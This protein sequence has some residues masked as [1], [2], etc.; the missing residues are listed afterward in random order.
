MILTQY[1]NSVR[2]RWYHTESW[3]IFTIVLFYFVL[4]DQRACQHPGDAT[5]LSRCAYKFLQFGNFCGENQQFPDDHGYLTNPESCGPPRWLLQAEKQQ[6]LNG[7]TTQEVKVGRQNGWSLRVGEVYYVINKDCDRD[8]VYANG[9]SNQWDGGDLV[10][11]FVIPA[12]ITLNDGQ[13]NQRKAKVRSHFLF[14]DII[15]SLLEGLIC[16]QSGVIFWNMWCLK[17][18]HGCPR[19]PDQIDRYLSNFSSSQMSSICCTDSWSCV[20]SGWIENWRKWIENSKSSCTAQ[21]N[22]LW[23]FLASVYI[24]GSATI[25]EDEWQMW[26]S[27]RWK[28]QLNGERRFGEGNLP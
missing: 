14:A 3:H 28:M 17:E 2:T 10:I 15:V 11:T 16:W 12:T 6:Y 26:M 1:E 9:G 20:K 24:L 22:L 5:Q 23:T 4:S 8:I 21:P 25:S 18:L 27:K 7:R 19:R 13:L